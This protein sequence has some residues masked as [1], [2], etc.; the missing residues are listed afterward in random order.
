MNTFVEALAAVAGDRKVLHGTP[1]VRSVDELL[2]GAAAARGQELASVR[3]QRVSLRCL[4][5]FAHVQGL[6]ALDGWAS[7]ILLLDPVTAEDRMA[8]FERAA[9]IVWR[10]TA[11]A[12]GL[13]VERVGEGPASDG[14]TEWIIPTSGTTGVPKLIGHTFRSLTRTVKK[15]T[16]LAAELVWG[17]LYDPT[18]FAGLQVILQGLV[19][20]SSL[21]VPRDFR[22]LGETVDF[23]AACGCNALSATPSLWRKLAIGGLL[24][25][26][27]LRLVTLGG[28]APDQK[29]LDLL[30]TVF[31][32]ATIRHIYASTEAG[33]GF[34][35]ADGLVGFPLAYL[36]EPPPGI[37]LRLREDG[38]L[39]LRPQGGGQRM[40]AGGGQLMDGE[41][42]VESG[43]MVEIREGRCYF[44]GRANGAI[45]VGGQKVHPAVLEEFL[46]ETE[47]VRAARVF[48]KRNPILGSLVAAEIIA[49]PGVDP[50]QLRNRLVDRCRQHLERYQTPAVWAFVDE[51][52]LTPTG[53]VQR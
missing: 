15:P 39:M 25:R 33:V 36:T 5:A 9:G 51:F 29:I 13:T 24:E 43:D 44:L 42:W 49:E 16:P 47:G 11:G 23:L 2:A 52:P 19:G 4:D 45:N 8:G 17:L 37:E 48:G 40:V 32:A 28:E 38:I 53:K 12:G 22:E 46:A 6:V 31:P 41:G 50:Q 18:R 35:V 3:G 14:T 34:S 7:A 20:G 26:L 1:G 27:H 10:V 30:R 21:I